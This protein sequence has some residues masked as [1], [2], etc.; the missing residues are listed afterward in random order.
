[1][2][3]FLKAAGEIREGP[4]GSDTRRVPAFWNIASARGAPVVLVNW[5]A[6]WPA[7]PVLGEVVSERSYLERLVHR[8]SRS[9][10]P[11][12][13][14]PAALHDE[15]AP[16]CTLPDQLSLERAHA[17]MDMT[18][19]EFE[20]VRTRSPRLPPGVLH[21]FA[22]Y[23]A[24]FD[25]DRRIA[26]HLVAR[27]PGADALVL[28]RLVDKMCHAALV[29][30]ELVDD[31]LRASPAGVERFGRLVTQAYREVDGALGELMDAFGEGNVLVVSDHCFQL[32]SK[33]RPR[34]FHEEAPDGVF[35]AAGPA[36]RAGPAPALSVYDL[37]PLLLWLKGYPLAEDMPGSLPRAILDPGLLRSRPAQRVA[38]YGTQDAPSLLRGDRAVD[39]EA[40]ERL[41]ALGYVRY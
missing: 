15:L 14:R 37:L 3:G 40:V 34:Y 24:A 4:V 9:P 20:L 26:R 19:E 7:E 11:D 35:L 41:R 32:E 12:L 27:N 39:S 31:H 29:Y 2:L 17:F 16:L 1:M 8:G 21:E 36:F 33:P 30:S 22:Y 18:P 28:F 13:T 23:V 25:S 6:T 10:T 5:W 38:S